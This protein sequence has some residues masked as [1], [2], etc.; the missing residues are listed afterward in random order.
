VKVRGNLAYGHIRD[1]VDKG[2]ITEERLGR[3]KV[4]RTTRTFADYFSLSSEPRIMR[5][6]LEKIFQQLEA[7]GKRSASL[8][9]QAEQLTGGG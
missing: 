1:L 8:E 7:K 4:L 2:L 3:T 5:Q 6:Q 9:S